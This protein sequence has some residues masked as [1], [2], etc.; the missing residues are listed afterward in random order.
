LV[1]SQFGVGWS[2]QSE[3]ATEEEATMAE[4]S[5]NL[6]QVIRIDDERVRDYLRNVVRGSVEETLNAMLEAEAERL[7]NAGRR[8]EGL[9][10]K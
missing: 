2:L 7:C 3:L 4:D 6:G 10:D 9:W 5:T 1:A 8:F